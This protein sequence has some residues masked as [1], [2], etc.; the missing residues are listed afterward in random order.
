MMLGVQAVCPPGTAPL[1]YGKPR[2]GQ[3][4]CAPGN[5]I[6]AAPPCKASP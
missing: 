6:P 5:L 4:E 3:P 1:S 2:P